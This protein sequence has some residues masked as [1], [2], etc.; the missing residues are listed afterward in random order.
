MAR[1]PVIFLAFANNSDGFLNKLKDESSELYSTLLPLEVAGAVRVVREESVRFEDLEKILGT[2]KD[3]IYLFHYAGHAEGEKLIFEDQDI[4]SEGLGRL[5]AAKKKLKLVFLNGCTTGDQVKFYLDAGVK[6]VIA[7]SIPIKDTE[8]TEFAKWFYGALAKAHSIREAFDFA[9]GLKKAK[10]LKSFTDD[11]NEKDGIVVYDVSRGDVRSLRFRTGST[12]P[13]PWKLLVREDAQGV[14]DWAIPTATTGLPTEDKKRDLTYVPYLASEKAIDFDD[15]LEKL[16]QHFKDQVKRKVPLLI[17]GMK[18]IGKSWLARQFVTVHRMSYGYAIWL[19]YQN[20]LND[21]I[22]G[23]MELVQNCLG[24]EIDLIKSK[25]TNTGNIFRKLNRLAGGGKQKNLLIID[26]VTDLKKVLD[27]LKPIDIH[28]WDILLTS[29]KQISSSNVEIQKLTANEGRAKAIFRSKCHQPI[30]DSDLTALLQSVEFHPL[31]A[32][33]IG[34]LMQNNPLVDFQRVQSIFADFKSRKGE[35]FYEGEGEAQDVYQVIFKLVPWSELNSSQRRLLYIFSLLP[36]T[37]VDGKVLIESIISPKGGNYKRRQEL[38]LAEIVVHSHLGNQIANHF[39]RLFGINLWKRSNS[40]DLALSKLVSWGMIHETNKSFTVHELIRKVFFN[41]V[42]S[43]IGRSFPK[44][45][46]VQAEQ[47]GLHLLYYGKYSEAHSVFS[48]LKELS[49]KKEFSYRQQFLKGTEPSNLAWM[50]LNLG[51]AQFHV[52][53]LRDS[54]ANIKEAIKIVYG[55]LRDISPGY[56]YNFI[57]IQFNKILVNARVSLARNYLALGNKES[58]RKELVKAKVTLDKFKVIK[59]TAEYHSM[60]YFWIAFYKWKTRKKRE[61]KVHFEAAINIQSKHF[62]VS[63]ELADYYA[64]YGKVSFETKEYAKAK[65][66]LDKALDIYVK[67]ELIW[68]PYYPAYV[69][70]HEKAVNM[71]KQ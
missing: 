51:E 16:L 61:A 56:W 1:I 38:K 53:N 41:R 11:T 64:G 20:N 14:L 45:I 50:Y 35:L 21:T 34:S 3:D 36:F 31:I 65:K 62:S 37:N 26:N 25:R 47:L 2:Y 46:M 22:F 40:L 13:F 18:G 54:I 60:Y 24:N 48:T 4:N 10:S 8:A 63:K 66:C 32:D 19:D 15:D 52:S 9:I 30:S 70:M 27:G 5:L 71:T 12:F 59:R 39:F 43:S 17:T 68:H 33:L 49:V 28:S 44:I 58:A 69:A 67:L 29:F 7:T 23:N 55:Q 42:I 57:N 6:A